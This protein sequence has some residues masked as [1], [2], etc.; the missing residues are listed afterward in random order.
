MAFVPH[1]WRWSVSGIWRVTVALGALH[2]AGLVHGAPSPSTLRVAGAAGRMDHAW[3]VASGYWLLADSRARGRLGR[4]QRVDDDNAVCP[5]DQGGVAQPEADGNVDA[6]GDAHH[7]AP[8]L[9]RVGGEVRLAPDAG[10]SGDEAEDQGTE[11]R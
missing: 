10:L 3:I 8:E 6:V 7:L 4:F 2:A 11:Q 5:L 9:L 1:A